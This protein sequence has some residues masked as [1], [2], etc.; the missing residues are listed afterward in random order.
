MPRIR[1]IPGPYRFFFASF[2]CTEPP[3]VHVERQDKTC[4]FWLEPL[5]LA[6]SHGFSARELNLIR[7]LIGTHLAAILER[8]YEH[9]G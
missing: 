7:R 9:C 8:W 4:K 1:G 3:H 6:R 5:E 2:D